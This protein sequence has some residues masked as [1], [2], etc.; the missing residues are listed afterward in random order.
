KNEKARLFLISQF[1]DSLIKR[2]F[3]VL[4]S[5]VLENDEAIIEEPILISKKEIALDN[6]GKRAVTQY[7]VLE[8]FQ[9]YTLVLAKPITQM[10]SQIRLHF[11]SIGHPLAIDPLY[12]SGAPIFLSSFKRKYKLKL[13]EK[14]KP[15]ISRMP[16]HLSRLI[17]KTADGEE[18]IISADLPKDFAIT[19]K[20]LKKYY[21]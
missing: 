1:K 9:G 16:I 12:S 5:G 21:S 13:N 6:R 14:E 2:E 18:K 7:Q 20:Q 3:I 19:V 17:L 8:K 10:R 11:Y 4:L 15:L